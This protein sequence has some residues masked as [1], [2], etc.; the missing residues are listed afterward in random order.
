MNKVLPIE[1]IAGAEPLVRLSDLDEYRFGL[2]NQLAG[3][4]DDERWTA[5]RVRFGVYGQ[6]QDGVQMVR[7]K[8]PGG[9]VPTPWLKTLARVNRSFAAGDA[10]IT[11]RQD[12]QIY[13][14]PLERTADLLQ[15]LYRDGI[16]TR[17]AC[18]NTLR[19]MTSCALAG[20]CPRE[21][22]DA[23]RVAEQLALSFIRNP[24]V[25]HM[26]RK[27]KVAVSGCATDCGSTAIHDL[28]LI[29]VEKDGAKGFRVVLG[30]GLGGMPRV[31]VPVLDFVSE[32]DV[33]TALE[34]GVRL[35]QR[36]SNRRDRNAARI[37][38]VAKRFGDEKFAEL[39]REEYD[40]IKGLGQRPWAKLDWRQPTEQP[41]ART[42]VGVVPGHDGKVAVVVYVPLGIVSS[43]QLDALHDIAVAA[44]V[45]EL[46]TTRDQNIAFLNVAPDQVA[47]ITAAV[48]AIGLDVPAQADA[49][50]D[51]ISCPG[52]TT[53]RI[54]IT[55][56]QLLAR[57]LISQAEDDIARQVAVHVSGCQNSCGLHHV[58]DIGLHGMAKKINGRAAPHYQIHLGGDSRTGLVGL[59]GPIIPARLAD[60]AVVLLRNGWAAGHH[61]GEGVRAWAQR[62]GKDGL[63]TLLA[64]ITGGDS[65]GLFVDWGEATG[66]NPP[67]Q[68][69]GDCAAPFAMDDGLAD[70]A[71]DGLLKLDRLIAAGRGDD[72]RQA[73]QE[74]A[75][76]AIRRLL[77]LKGQ[78][79]E[80]DVTWAAG[81]AAAQSLWSDD[82]EVLAALAGVAATAAVDEYREAVI[83]VIDTAGHRVAAPPVP[84]VAAMGDLAAIL[85]SGE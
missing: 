14:V 19:N 41:V 3:A 33:P 15:D 31:A 47:T 58:A 64:P 21:H 85:G 71:E 13:Y 55:S 2:E 43:D 54:G 8:I 6:K 68:A 11:T 7:I 16:T 5:F 45:R 60:E 84:A 80:D 17:E 9:V 36:Y 72:A 30:G 22:V 65:D 28:G 4:W 27:F 29:A 59:S 25:Q 81:L 24:L 44:Q 12:F 70:L 49:V 20:A 52:T 32:D 77:L 53:C 35:H 50:P 57:Q 66:F 63:A 83:G 39:Y 74:A 82:A 61:P 46:R 10:H 75:L 79:A 37:K 1:A 56:S 67:G 73:G 69:R 42:P 51:I 18:G 34:A 48:K 78:P 76:F 26:P 23:G 62:L 40:R 38:Y